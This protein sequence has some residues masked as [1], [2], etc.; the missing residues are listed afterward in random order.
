MRHPALHPSAY[1]H[2]RLLSAGAERHAGESARP[3]RS[4]GSEANVFSSCQQI[5][6]LADIFYGCLAV[7][8]V[9]RAALLGSGSLFSV[10]IWISLVWIAIFVGIWHVAYAY[11][12]HLHLDAADLTGASS[13]L[14]HSRHGDRPSLTPDVHVDGRPSRRRQ[15]LL[16]CQADAG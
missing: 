5:W 3:P 6:L 7:P 2:E 10:P 16:R 14:G 4:R 8:F 15:K 1:T 9:W 11:C 12:K 13:Q